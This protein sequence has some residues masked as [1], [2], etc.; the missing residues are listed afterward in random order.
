MLKSLLNCLYPKPLQ[1]HLHTKWQFGISCA[2]RMLSSS[3][4][5]VTLIIIFSCVSGPAMGRWLITCQPVNNVESEERHG[6]VY[7]KLLGLAYL[8]E[9]KI[10]HDNLCSNSILVGS[11]GL[12]K[13][14][15]FQVSG[16]TT[17][18][19]GGRIDLGIVVGKC[20]ARV[21]LLSK[22]ARAHIS[23]QRWIGQVGKFSSE[24][25]DNNILWRTNGF[26]YWFESLASPRTANEWCTIFRFR[27]L[28]FLS[29]C[30]CCSDGG[31]SMETLLR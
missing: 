10:I 25:F 6:N 4:E 15:N 11:D 3:M 17:I 2:I 16:S 27:H 23:R 24:W 22:Q 5:C 1:R 19:S 9:R 29:L 7:I 21:W 14:A 31:N 28:F 30:Y 8:H 18:F 12:V 20:H 13:L 26:G